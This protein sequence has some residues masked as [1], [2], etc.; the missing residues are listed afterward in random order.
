MPWSQ[1]SQHDRAESFVAGH[2]LRMACS[3]PA[4]A[5]KARSLHAASLDTPHVEVGVAVQTR[6]TR[7]LKAARAE[8]RAAK[9]DTKALQAEVDALQK[10][11]QVLTFIFSHA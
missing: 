3:R 1:Q 9:E 8:W 10:Q 6:L 7:Q 5:S 11:Q 4:A 2:A